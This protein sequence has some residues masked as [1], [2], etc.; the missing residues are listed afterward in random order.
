MSSNTTAAWQFFLFLL[1]LGAVSDLPVVGER[2]GERLITRQIEQQRFD[3]EFAV[4]I[5]HL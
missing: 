1:I 5:E 2:I 4:I 3:R